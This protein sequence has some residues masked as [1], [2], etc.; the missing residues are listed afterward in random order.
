MSS[1]YLN[2][3][4]YLHGEC[5]MEDWNSTAG[6]TTACNGAAN[7]LSMYS[8]PLMATQKR[9]PTGKLT[10][11]MDFVDPNPQPVRVSLAGESGHIYP[12]INN[13][14]VHLLNYFP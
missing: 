14:N 6:I 8:C 12:S 2:G 3:Y 1:A 5:M 11:V 4:D 13:L 10:I 7:G 9:F